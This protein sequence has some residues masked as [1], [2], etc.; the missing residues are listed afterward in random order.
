MNDDFRRVTE[1]IL[2]QISMRDAQRWAESFAKAHGM[3]LDDG[4]SLVLTDEQAV[5]EYGSPDRD[6]APWLLDALRE[7]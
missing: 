5:M 1:T 6:G 7:G 3:M 4:P 2:R